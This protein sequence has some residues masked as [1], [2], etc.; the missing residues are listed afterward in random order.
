MDVCGNVERS[1]AS[2]NGDECPFLWYNQELLVASKTRLFQEQRAFISSRTPEG[3]PNRCPVCHAD[4][5]VEP[6]LP[7]GDA[8]CPVCGHLLW[9]ITLTPGTRYFDATN[10]QGLR[11]RVHQLLAKHLGIPVEE[12]D[13]EGTFFQ[14]LRA[15]SLDIVELVME[16]DDAFDELNRGGDA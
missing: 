14:D 12:V 2:V 9:F 10:A 7:F 4:I 5:K 6:S 11:D 15:D 13:S 3:E 16:F 1:I 8:P